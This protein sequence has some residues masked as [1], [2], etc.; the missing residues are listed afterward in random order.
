M[1]A[2]IFHS[3]LYSFFN[4]HF[5]NTY[6]IPVIERGTGEINMTKGGHKVY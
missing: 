3:F 4:K 2:F 6:Y 1:I 5:S